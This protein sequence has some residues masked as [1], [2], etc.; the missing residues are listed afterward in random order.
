[1][2]ARLGSIERFGGSARSC[3]SLAAERESERSPR[4]RRGV[5]CRSKSAEARA[6][7]LRV[8]EESYFLILKTNRGIGRVVFLSV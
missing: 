5:T 8:A 1:M 3:L 2:R 4:A 7:L 6:L